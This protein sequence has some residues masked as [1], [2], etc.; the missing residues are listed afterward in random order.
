[1]APY[2]AVCFKNVQFD[3]VWFV[4]ILLRT[5]CLVQQGLRAFLE[6]VGLGGGL[7]FI[8]SA[9]SALSNCL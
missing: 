7:A 9:F 6:W 8:V 2:T 3:Q 1:M 5:R 4:E